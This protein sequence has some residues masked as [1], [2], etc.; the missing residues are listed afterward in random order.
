MSI[1]GTARDTPDLTD[2]RPVDIMGLTIFIDTKEERLS[3]A[4]GSGA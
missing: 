1:E 3:L 2:G 4:R